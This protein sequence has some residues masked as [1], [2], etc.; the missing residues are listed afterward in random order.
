[1]P[2][3]LTALDLAMV[4][5]IDQWQAEARTIAQ[6]AGIFYNEVLHAGLPGD[7]AFQLTRDWMASQ[8][9]GYVEFMPE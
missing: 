7:F 4:A 6:T 9:G 1:M 8:T 3:N 5:E 2:E